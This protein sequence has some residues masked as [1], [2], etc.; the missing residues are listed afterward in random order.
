MLEEI[1]AHLNKQ[2]PD[3]CPRIEVSPF[4]QGRLVGRRDVI[5][6]IQLHLEKENPIVFTTESSEDRTSASTGTRRGSGS[7]YHSTR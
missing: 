5:E 7:P 4:D 1:I 3:R 2:Y 6:Q